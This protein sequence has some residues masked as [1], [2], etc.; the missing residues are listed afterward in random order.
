MVIAKTE[1][2]TVYITVYNWRGGV[3]AVAVITAKINNKNIDITKQ[4]NKIFIILAVAV[5]IAKIKK[6]LIKNVAKKNNKNKN[7]END[8]F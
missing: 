8:P 5:I 6:L 1:D 4:K 2:I 3:L 7:I